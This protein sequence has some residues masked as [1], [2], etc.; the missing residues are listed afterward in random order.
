MR[1]LACTLSCLISSL[2]NFSRSPKIN[3]EVPRLVNK[4]Q[5]SLA[6][7]EL[8]QKNA[9]PSLVCG[10]QKFTYKFLN[11][12]F[13]LHFMLIIAALKL[14]KFLQTTST[15]KA[16]GETKQLLCLS[17]IIIISLLFRQQRKN[18]STGTCCRNDVILAW[19]QILPQSNKGRAKGIITIRLNKVAS[20]II[21]FA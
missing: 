16:R 5:K 1:Y 20:F 14:S 6:H 17:Y 9:S 4:S 7:I 11:E 3:D 19:H 12:F 18:G 15:I 2:E 21:S 8:K 10:F 13:S